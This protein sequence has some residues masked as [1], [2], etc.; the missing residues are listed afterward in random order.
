MAPLNALSST[1]LSI[2]QQKQHLRACA[3]ALR[4]AEDAA[5]RS[6]A[7][8][9]IRAR[10][11]ALPVYQ[12]AQT[13]LC[14]SSRGSEV[15]TRRFIEDMLEEGKTVCTPRCEGGGIMHAHAIT[16]SGDLEEGKYGIPAPAEESPL[17]LPEALDLILVPCVSCS[18]QGHRLGYG[19]GYYDRYLPRASRATSVLVCREGLLAQTLPFE[20]HDVKANLVVTENEIITVA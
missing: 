1:S 16:S 3:L 17:I 2:S 4:D 19:G 8:A 13:V 20:P 9:R 10:L 5:S 14:Y 11:M 6:A 15:D 12:A 18:R 7:D